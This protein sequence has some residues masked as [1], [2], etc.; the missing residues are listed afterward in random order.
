MTE[1]EDSMGIGE[2][3]SAKADAAI[4]S[5]LPPKPTSWVRKALKIFGSGL[6]TGAADDDPSG[7]ATYSS[8]GAQFGYAMLR[9]MPLIYPFMQAFRRS[10]PVSDGSRDEGSRA[11]FAIFILPG[12]CTSS[13]LHF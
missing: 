2:E 6:V 9:T 13:L 10:A 1:E 8:V 4:T 11:T 3:A 7:I 5:V 12:C